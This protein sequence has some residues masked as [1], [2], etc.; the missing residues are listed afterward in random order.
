M[1]LQGLGSFGGRGQMRLVWLGVGGD[2]GALADLADRVA[3]SLA[4]LGF[5]HDDR[6]FNAHLTLARVRDDTPPAIRERLHDLLVRFNTPEFPW[7]RVERISLMQS[8]LTNGGSIYRSLAT[9][10]LEGEEQAT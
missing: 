1:T 9:Y 3:D 7:F 10:A 5:E 4:P 8:T 2:G 6:G